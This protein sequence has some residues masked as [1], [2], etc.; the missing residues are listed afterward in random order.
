MTSSR[1]PTGTFIGKCPV[2]KTVHVKEDTPSYTAWTRPC[3]GRKVSLKPVLAR[4]TDH[5]CGPKCTSAL[6]PSCDCECG[7]K[8]HGADH[9]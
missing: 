1:I 2:C 3:C 6:G 4:V 7:G 9:R 5:K 8:N